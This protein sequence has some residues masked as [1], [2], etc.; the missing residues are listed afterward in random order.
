MANKT[1]SQP[2]ENAVHLCIDM[3]SIFRRG[4]VWETPWMERVLPVVIQIASQTAERTIFTRFITPETIQQS[5]GQWKV[6]YK[7]WERATRQHL[8][9]NQLDLIPELARFVPPALVVNKPVYSAFAGSELLH[10]LL[11][12]N[13]STLVI[14]GAETDVCVL[15]TVLDAVDYGFR[16]LII[17]DAL[18]SSSDEGHDALMTL[19][20][21]RFSEQIELV[22]AETFRELWTS[23]EQK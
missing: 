7:K 10:L 14:T 22:S 12:K 9:A 11:N 1:P 21:K 20:Q 23:S 5:T 6:F 17:E 18:C 8:A 15:A 13:V 2:I 16:V 19:Y 3:Q 4:G